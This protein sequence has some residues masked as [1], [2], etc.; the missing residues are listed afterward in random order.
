MWGFILGTAGLLGWA[1]VK[2]VMEMRESAGGI[3]GAVL[4]ARGA[5]AVPVGRVNGAGGR[6]DAGLASGSD[7]GIR[8]QYA[9]V[10][11]HSRENSVF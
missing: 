6:P 10:G 11:G 5:G 2:K 7:G 8:G 1:G 9:S 4:G 3:A